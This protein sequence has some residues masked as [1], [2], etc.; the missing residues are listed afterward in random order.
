[1]KRD[2]S[3]YFDIITS[4]KT[5]GEVESFVG[6]IDTLML[7]FFES[8]EVSPEKMLDS[9]SEGSSLKIRQVFAKNNLNFNNR[10]TVSKFFKTLKELIKKLK[11]IKIVLAFDPSAKTIENIHNFIT[12]S[13]G[14]GY[15]LEIEVLQEILAGAIVIFNG[16]YIDFSLRKRIED[17]FK[18]KADQIVSAIG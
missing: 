12:D 10:E 9:I 11:A 6:E 8:E 5:T 1:V 7:K 15:I 4:L 16:K 17:T 13:L 14:I 3:I 18:E 2:V